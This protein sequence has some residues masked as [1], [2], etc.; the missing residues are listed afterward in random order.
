MIYIAKA[1]KQY[2]IGYSKHPPKRARQLQT[3]NGYK[4]HLVATFDGGKEAEASVH[5]YLQNY[6]IEGEWFEG[7]PVE[8]YVDHAI[9]QGAA[10]VT[11]D[12]I[13]IPAR[14]FKRHKEKV[15]E[16]LP[17]WKAELESAKHHL[18]SNLGTDCVPSFLGRRRKRKRRKK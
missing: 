6:R 16:A 4:I 5:R 8:E 12:T 2:K 3:G 9:A 1:G 15:A 14:R 17:S 7:E 18:M 13:P 11:M 10:A